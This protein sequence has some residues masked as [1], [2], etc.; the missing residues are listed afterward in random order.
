MT[1]K[2][3]IPIA[4][5]ICNIVDSAERAKIAEAIGVVCAK[6]NAEFNWAAWNFACRVS[7]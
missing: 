1:K 6:A 4:V 3:F 5:A 7:T 2:Q